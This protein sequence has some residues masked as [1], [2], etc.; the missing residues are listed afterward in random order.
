MSTKLFTL[1]DQGTQVILHIYG[2]LDVSNVG[3][4]KIATSDIIANVPNRWSGVIV[5]LQGLD[6]IDSSGVSAIVGLYK[7][8]RAN[9]GQ[10]LVTGARGQPM[11][12]FQ[13]LRMDKIFGR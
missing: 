3:E 12:V 8:A 2:K 6:L 11:Q 13:I 4:L 9:H 1:E 5:N 10:V 7:R